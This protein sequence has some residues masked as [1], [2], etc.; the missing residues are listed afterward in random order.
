MSTFDEAALAVVDGKLDRLRELL[1]SEPDLVRARSND[2]FD[3]TLLHYV[4][5]NGVRDE[6]Q[7]TPANAVE[8]CQMLLAAGAEPNATGRAYGGGT[9]QTPLVLLVSSWPPFERGIQDELVHTLV[10]GGARVNGLDD[11]GM[12]L[13]TALVFGY[14]DAAVALVAAGARVDNVFFAAGL[15]DL[16]AVRGFFDEAGALRHDA[17]GT[18]TPPIPKE[19]GSDP[20]AHV[21]EALHFAVT[22]GRQDV[23]AWLLERGADVDGRTEGHHCELPLLQAAFVHEVG[24][25]R[26]LVERGADPDLR[27]GKRGLSAREHV[28][29]FGPPELDLDR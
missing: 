16:A 9:N 4:A 2:E 14:T 22:H 24:M 10:A 20:S 11:D 23:A 29:R 17:L 8:V 1:A 6:L 5:A 13:A 25:A 27:C 18:Y 15:G 19:L 3:A 12:P 21:Q 26:W 7:R 28:A